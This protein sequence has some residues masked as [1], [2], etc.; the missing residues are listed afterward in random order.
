MNKK[1]HLLKENIEYSKNK[2]FLK[3]KIKNFIKKHKFISSIAFWKKRK[4]IYIEKWEEVNIKTKNRYTMN[5][6][7]SF[8][9]W[10][11]LIKNADVIHRNDK[12]QFELIW[13]TPNWDT[14]IIHIRED[15]IKKDKFKFYV[16][17]YIWKK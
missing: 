12:D 3:T 6:L 9:C 16:S 2:M 7:K 8:F 14:I 4:N 10:I 13:V 17:S 11:E 1:I 15:K 5:R